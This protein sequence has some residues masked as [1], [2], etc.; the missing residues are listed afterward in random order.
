[1]GRPNRP[2]TVSQNVAAEIREQ[3]LRREIKG[4]ERLRQEAI[5]K[6]FEISI[7]PVREALRQLAAEGLV[8]LV[9]HRGAIA[10]EFT[11]EKALE[12]IDMR[13]MIEADLIGRALDNITEEDIVSAEKIL[14]EFD[15][16]LDH[17]RDM[18][19][20]SKYNWSFHST[21]YLP[22]DRPETMKVLASLH[23]KCDRY[24]RLQLSDGQHIVRAEEE[25]RELIDLCRS[26]SKRAAKALMKK[27]MIGIERDIA[28]QLGK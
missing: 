19:H 3:I 20:W 26:R 7:I 2:L 21:L 6:S 22:A 28:E 17:G 5:A 25:H 4:G 23:E 10:T 1:M 14:N 18:E 27:H 12:W 24:H 8:E 16:A 11:L 15:A 9:P 13:Q